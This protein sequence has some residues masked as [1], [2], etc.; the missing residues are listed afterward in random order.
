MHVV[1]GSLLSYNTTLKLI[2]GL[3]DCVPPPLFPVSSQIAMF[4]A[5]QCHIWQGCK[6][7]SMA[8]GAERVDETGAR[9]NVTQITVIN[10]LQFPV[11]DSSWHL[12]GAAAAAHLPPPLSAR[13]PARPHKRCCV[14]VVDEEQ[15]H[16]IK[17]GIYNQPFD[18][19]HPRLDYD[20]AS[21]WLSV[22]WTE[23]W[24]IYLADDDEQGAAMAMV[25]RPD[26]DPG[27]QT[28]AIYCPAI[29]NCDTKSTTD[30]KRIYAELRD[31][32]PG[33]PAF[34]PPPHPPPAAPALT[35]CGYVCRCDGAACNW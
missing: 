20:N 29:P 31:Q 11:D 7:A 19:I 10:M 4:V 6:H 34:T 17:Y 13:P 9:V 32:R 5:D 1:T 16:I 33:V 8:R 21:A 24:T 28:N 3:A 35:D 30:N 18:I 15:K 14:L 23:Q 25:R 27:A 22:N 26:F 2:R 12:T